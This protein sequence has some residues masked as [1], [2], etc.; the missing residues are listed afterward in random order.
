MLEL[1]GEIMAWAMR[2]ALAGLKIVDAVYYVSPARW[3][4]LEAQ[5]KISPLRELH[6]NTV[7]GAVRVLAADDVNQVDT[8]HLI[9]SALDY[10]RSL[11]VLTPE[12]LCRPSKN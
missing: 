8:F 9:M 5:A 10:T 4:K 7:I 6:V 3:A 12:A 2:V 1:Q 11:G